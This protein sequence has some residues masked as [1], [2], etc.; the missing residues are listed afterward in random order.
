MPTNSLTRPSSARIHNYLLGG[1]DNYAEDRAMAQ[2]AVA[3]MPFLQSAVHHER[4]YALLMVQALA[5]AGIR[6]LVDFGC[7]M[8]HS[9][10]PVNVITRVHPNARAVCIDNDALVHSYTSA[11]MRAG[12][13]AAVAH[14]RA[15]IS[16]PESVLA[17]REILQT[18]NWR[19]PVILL[20]GSVLHHIDDTPAR[21]LSAIVDQYKMV[22]APGSA[23][24]VT[25]ATADFAGKPARKTAKAMTAAGCP[26]YLRTKEQIAPLFNDWHLVPP[27][28]AEPQGVALDHPVHSQ[29][30]SYAGM[31]RK[32]ARWLSSG[33]LC[34]TRPSTP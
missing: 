14:L 9:P 6:Q 10:D 13:P 26:V 5:I 23:L 18:I 29:T 2:R 15:D 31:A 3:K 20:F 21:P 33:S 12:A 22:A 17:S 7:G 24:V 34:L 28:L 30:A 32:E 8:P 4:M 27:G 1:Q 25:H 19:E 11:L 16:E